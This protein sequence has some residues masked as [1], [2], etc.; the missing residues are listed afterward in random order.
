MKVST[1]F[2]ALGAISIVAASPPK[3]AARDKESYASYRGYGELSYQ[4]CEGRA[5]GD[6]AHD[7]W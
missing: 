5:N 2:A 1:V 7:L 4:A 6:V 3:L